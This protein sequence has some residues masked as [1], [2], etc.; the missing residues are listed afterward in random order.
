LEGVEL[1]PSVLA[2]MEDSA[3]R[4]RQAGA[5]L[6]DV[7][8]VGYD[9]ARM[10]REGLLI[11]EAEAA[12]AWASILEREDGVSETLRGMISYG[13]RQPAARLAQAQWRVS[14]CALTARQAFTQ[15]DALILPTAAHTAFPV[16]QAAP[17]AQA[18]LTTLANLAGLPAASVPAPVPLGALPVG[19]QL[20][21]PRGARWISPGTDRTGQRS[22]AR[23]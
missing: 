20:I 6:V 21:A 14:S 12:V 3:D 18:D 2:A 11:L 15:C 7:E 19:L 8:L 9:F 4:L 13:S 5:E 23:R 16:E 17:A 22:A 10:R 1:E